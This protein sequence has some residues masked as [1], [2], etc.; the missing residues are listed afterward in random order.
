MLSLLQN[1]Y[2]QRI[3]KK[4]K[5]IPRV[6]LKRKVIILLLNLYVKATA[7]QRAAKI[8]NYLIKRDIKTVI[9]NIWEAAQKLVIQRV[10]GRGRLK[11]L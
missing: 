10:K 9:N 1:N 5:C 3:I 7:L 6:A 11:R 4:Y 2:L 8:V